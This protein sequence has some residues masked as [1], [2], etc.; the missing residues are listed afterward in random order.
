MSVLRRVLVGEGWGNFVGT[1]LIL[2][3]GVALV[4]AEAPRLRGVLQPEPRVMACVA[5]LAGPR[6]VRWVT[7]EDCAVEG[8]AVKG[9]SPGLRVEGEVAPGADLTGLVSVDGDGYLLTVGARPARTR[10]LGTTLAGFLVLLFGL[11]PIARRVAV[12]RA[13]PKPPPPESDAPPGT[14]RG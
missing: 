8:G 7:L 6:E 10:V 5:W 13:L 1:L 9:A 11:W 3:L 4:V 12:E 14:R 2:A